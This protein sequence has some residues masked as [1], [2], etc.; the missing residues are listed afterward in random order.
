M[1]IIATDTTVTAVEPKDTDQLVTRL[2]QWMSSVSS[3]LIAYSGGVDSA[4][5]MAVAHQCL[6]ERA[7]ACI[8]VSPSYPQRELA[9]AIAVAEQLGARHRLVETQEHLNP[10][11]AANPHNRCYFCKS[12]LYGRLQKLAAEESFAVILDGTN[13]SDLGGHR[14]GYAAAKEKGVRSPLAELGFTKQDVRAVARQLGLPVWDKPASP[15]LASRVPAGIAVVP[16]LLRRIERAEDVLVRLGFGDFR[17]RHHGDVA[18]VEL[19][20]SEMQAALDRRDDIVEGIRAAGY[21]FVCLD[22]AGFKSGSLQQ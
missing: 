18:R 14:P 11:Y 1:T 17:V 9:A 21:R 7:L 16:E 10:S 12:E 5:V 4:L 20:V 6:G 2:R 22:L 15:C 19:P 8:G 3:A 13:A